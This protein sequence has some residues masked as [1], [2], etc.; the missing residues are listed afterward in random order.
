MKE[1]DRQVLMSSTDSDPLGL[2][3]EWGTPTD[4][5]EGVQDLLGLF[6]LDAAASK[7]NAKV[8]IAGVHPLGFKDAKGYDPYRKG[9]LTKQ[10]DALALP[11][12]GRVWLNPPYGRAIAAWVQKV[13]EESLRPEVELV[14]V[15]LPSR[16]DL[17]WFQSVVLAEASLLYFIAG[18]LRFEGAQHV[19]PF[20]SFLAVFRRPGGP[21]RVAAMDR[22]GRPRRSS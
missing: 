16:T 9:F 7:E 10:D 21:A 20:P 1:H 17:P 11:W 12:R 14:A 2:K 6:T 13:R 5:F 15:L 3:G 18:R 4:F 19:A 22:L 8:R